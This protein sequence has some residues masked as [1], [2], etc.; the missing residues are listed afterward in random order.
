M[1]ADKYI[2]PNKVNMGLRVGGKSLR[3][4]HLVL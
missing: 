4:K 3:K 1:L 2:N